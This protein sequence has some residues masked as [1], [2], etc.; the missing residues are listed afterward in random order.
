MRLAPRPGER[1]DREATLRFLFDGHPVTGLGGDTIGSALYAGGRRVFSR[2]FKYHRPRG[3]LCCS[4]RCANCMMTVDGIPN[5]RV[6]LEPAPRGSGCPFAERDRLC[7]PRS[8]QH[9]RSRRR[10]V[11][12]GR[13]LLPDDD[14][15][16]TGVAA[17]RALPPARRRPRPRARGDREPEIR[18]RAPA[19]RRAR[20]RRRT[21]G[22]TGGGRGGSRGRA[23]PPR[24]RARRERSGWIRVARACACDRDLR[25]RPRAGRRRQPCSTGCAPAASLSPPARSS[26]R[27]CSPATTSSE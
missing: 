18:H 23:C 6:C 16:A 26:S 1:I 19:G 22:S 20:D 24:R 25:G 11:H 2:S 14:P 21:L 17:V 13:L 10:P 4:G 8:A 15:A 5:V 7:R 27:S 12:A 3:L 9:R